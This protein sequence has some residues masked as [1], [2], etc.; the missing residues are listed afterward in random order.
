MLL[1]LTFDKGNQFHYLKLKQYD[2]K[3]HEAH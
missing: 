2:S 3:A 1:F